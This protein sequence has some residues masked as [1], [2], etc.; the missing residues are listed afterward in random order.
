MNTQL[1]Q[2]G[3]GLAVVVLGGL[4]L[5][6]WSRRAP[7]GSPPPPPVGGPVVLGGSVGRLRLGQNATMGGHLMAKAPDQLVTV[8][9]PYVLG[10]T[11]GGAPISWRYR[12]T[13]RMG[14]STPGGWKD[15]DQLGFGIG[16]GKKSFIVTNTGSFEQT[17]SF[18]APNDPDDGQIYD[19]HAALSAAQVADP[20]GEPTFDFPESKHDGAFRIVKAIKLAGS[21]G[22]IQVTQRRTGRL[23]GLG[24]R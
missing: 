12:L 13:I 7:T 14:H 4:A 11:K 21:V 24:R 8:T 9:V 17:F 1:E 3:N 15:A 22:S 16:S 10:T 18:F 6:A 19:V 2:R 5:W 23:V 20:L